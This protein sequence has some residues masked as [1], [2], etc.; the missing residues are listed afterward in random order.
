M[1]RYDA[2][3][4]FVAISNILDND[5]TE[6]ADASGSVGSLLP[7]VLV[8][9]LCFLSEQSVLVAV[10]IQMPH[11]PQRQSGL[12]V[13]FRVELHHLDPVGS[14]VGHEGNIMLLGHGVVNG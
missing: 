8:V 6:V 7:Y 5:T 12:G 10:V 1:N 14:D 13:A 9:P 2:H 3:C 11:S 4:L